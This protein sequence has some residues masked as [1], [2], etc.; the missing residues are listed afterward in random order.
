MEIIAIITALEHIP[1]EFNLYTDSKYVV[2]L[3]PDIETALISGGS[4]II[5]LLLH[6][7]NIMQSREGKFS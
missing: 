5:S 7:Q 3:F 2:H 6:L 4:R 1:E